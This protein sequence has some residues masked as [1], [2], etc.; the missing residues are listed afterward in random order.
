VKRTIPI[1]LPKD[2]DLLATMRLFRNLAN[3][4]SRMAFEVRDKLNRKFDLRRHC[5]PT[6]RERYPQV[7]SRVLEYIIKIVAGC[8]SKRKCEKLEEP[9]VFKKDFALLDKRLFRFDGQT[10]NIWTIAGRKEYPFTFVPTRRFKELWEKA[11]DIDSIILKKC[12]GKIIAHVCLTIPTPQENAGNHYVGIDLGAVCPIV[13]VRDDG[14]IFF[15][16]SEYFH[17][18]RKEFLEQRRYLQKKLATQRW[19]KKDAHNTVRALKRLSQRQRRFTRQYIHWAINRL[20]TWAGN[21]VI[22]MERLRLPKGKK[23]K[24]AKVLNRTLSLL[25][26]GIVKNAIVQKAQER[27]LKVVFVNPAGTSQTCPQ[28]GA[29]G[30]RTQRN[31]KC[32]SCGFSCHADIVGAMNILRRGLQGFSHGGAEAGDEP[33]KPSQPQ[34]SVDLPR[35]TGAGSVESHYSP[36]QERLQSTPKRKRATGGRLQPPL[37]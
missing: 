16:N 15:P 25:P 34:N 14:K 29:Q 33:A 32:P 26:Y 4:V 19:L 17:K 31:F 10:L 36:P 9:A 30:E 13:A 21:A 7:N 11:T 37:F 27:G 8:Y 24:G 28:C 2:G 20:L 18:K 12:N 3:E 35:P 5:Y 1:L 22:I 23:I 6:L